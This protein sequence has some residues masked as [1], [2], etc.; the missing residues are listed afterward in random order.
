[1]TMPAKYNL[2]PFDLLQSQINLSDKINIQNAR[3]EQNTKQLSKHK[4]TCQ[5]SSVNRLLMEKRRK[6]KFLKDQ[7]RINCIFL[8]IVLNPIKN[9]V[10]KE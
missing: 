5:N 7:I 4:L 8:M 9:N 1:M 3:E 2:T 6:F 10:D